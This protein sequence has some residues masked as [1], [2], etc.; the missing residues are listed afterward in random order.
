MRKGVPTS[1]EKTLGRLSLGCEANCPCQIL[2]CDHCQR[3]A[4]AKQSSYDF[5]RISRIENSKTE[6]WLH[7]PVSAMP[8]MQRLSSA[9]M[10]LPDLPLPLRCLHPSTLGTGHALLLC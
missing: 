4:N 6:T 10:S 1:P 2:R 5:R 9:K 7:S 8:E 3:L